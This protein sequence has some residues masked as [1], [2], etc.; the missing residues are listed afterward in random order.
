MRHTIAN[1][2][3][4]TILNSFKQPSP[5][6]DGT[7]IRRYRVQI[8]GGPMLTRALNRSEAD[9]VQTAVD[10]ALDFVAFSVNKKEST[11]E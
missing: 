9:V 11:E 1:K 2:H 8:A 7:G 4:E 3:F 10:E 5:V 6:G